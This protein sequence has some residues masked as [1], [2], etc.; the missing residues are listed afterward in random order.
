[1]GRLKVEAV[2]DAIPGVNFVA[3]AATAVDAAL[4]AQELTALKRETDAAL[5]CAHNGPYTLDQLRVSLGDESFS[6]FDAFKKIDLVKQFGPAGDG[7]EYHHIVEQSAEDEIP[8]EQLQSTQNIVRIPTLLHEEISSAFSKADG[9]NGIS[10]RDGLTGASF[11][12]R[13][14]EGIEV[15][16]KIGIVK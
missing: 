13:W 6:S 5:E 4:M 11:E 16:K 14:N 15:M 12:T 7:Y 8:A 2:G 3:G 9:P 1:M 10:V